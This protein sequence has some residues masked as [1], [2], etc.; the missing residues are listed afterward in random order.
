MFAI[1]KAIK[2]QFSRY[3]P[4]LEVKSEL[5]EEDVYGN[6]LIDENEIKLVVRYNIRPLNVQDFIEIGISE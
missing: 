1:H 3:L 6:S 5:I 4:F 2:D